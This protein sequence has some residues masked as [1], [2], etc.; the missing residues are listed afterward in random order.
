ME[1]QDI[2]LAEKAY[3]LSAIM[4]FCIEKAKE[5]NTD[6]QC[7]E[8]VARSMLLLSKIRHIM[9][10]AL[11]DEEIEIINKDAGKDGAKEWDM[12]KKAN[13]SEGAMALLEH[14]ADKG[15]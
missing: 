11:T 1:N 8:W 7:M 15:R 3:E 14:Y 10:E 13:T 4:Q 6:K 5:A 9:S 2:A 12:W